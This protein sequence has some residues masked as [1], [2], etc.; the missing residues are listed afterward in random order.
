MKGIR[1]KEKAI[2]ENEEI[3]KIITSAKYITVA[4][5]LENTPYLVTLSHGYDPEKHC[6]YFHCASEGKKVDILKKNNLV[7]G[8]AVLDHGYI[9][10]Q[11]DHLFATAQFNGRVHFVDSMDEKHHALRT[12]IHSLDA[13]PEEVESEHI[14]T[15]SVSR[16]TIGRIT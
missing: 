9:D 3:T 10:G 11:C 4:M 7:W 15:K 16:V 2:K 12:M 1:R 13:S 14:T 8:Q 6:I 5:C